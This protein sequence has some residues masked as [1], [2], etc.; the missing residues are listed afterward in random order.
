MALNC[1]I[2]CLEVSSCG[3]YVQTPPGAVFTPY[4]D[5]VLG[6]A[7][8]STGNGLVDSNRDAVITSFEYGFELGA[9]GFGADFEITDSTGRAS[10]EIIENLNKTVAGA[11]ESAKNVSFDFGW[12]VRNTNNT[13]RFDTVAARTGLRINGIIKSIEQAYEG[14]IIKIKFSVVA[15]EHFDMTPQ[16]LVI[17]GDPTKE[18]DDLPV[19]LTDAIEILLTREVN[20]KPPTYP[21][22]KFLNKDGG[23]LEF[24]T[25]NNTDKFKGPKNR[26]S[27]NGSPKIDAVRNWLNGIRSKDKRGLLILTDPM[28]GGIIIKEDPID[29]NSK[30]QDYNCAL[31]IGSF[32]VNGGNCS[33]VL[34]FRPTINFT[35]AAQPAPVQATSGAASAA[36]K[37]YDGKEVT[38]QTNRQSFGQGSN[39]TIPENMNT[40]VAPDDQAKSVT[41]THEAQVKSNAPNEIPS[42]IESDLKIIG[43]VTY[44]INLNAAAA[45]T[46]SLIF[47]NPFHLE[48]R[49]DFVEWY[50]LTQSNCHKLLSNKQWMVKGINH[51]IQSGTYVTNLKLSLPAPNV[52][53]EYDQPY[54]GT[55][56]A[57]AN[58]DPSP[59]RKLAAS[60]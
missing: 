52:E 59:T 22:V 6:G 45:A 16:D 27:T 30:N 44:G 33:P 20:G 50:G 54:G 4:V 43:N 11:V 26:W 37:T 60:E 56:A 31:H 46:V 13:F 35:N 7:R 36:G 40:Q 53:L 1:T 18:G 48:K 5:V 28:T 9:K 21:S 34:E 19:H 39:T 3:L 47:L 14:K 24:E 15:P 8:I 38:D 10:I 12:I 41:D 51:Q 2:P 32:V 58:K 42:A 23:K 49:N 29:R 55:G 17:G 57:K 25:T